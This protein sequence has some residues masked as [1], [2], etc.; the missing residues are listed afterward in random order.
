MAAPPGG[1]QGGPAVGILTIFTCPSPSSQ[2]NRSPR[3]ITIGSIN[4]DLVVRSDRLPVAGETMIAESSAWLPGGKGANQA[5][6]A[7][8]LGARV[9]FAGCVGRDAC[10]DDLRRGLAASGV[11]TEHLETAETAS[12]L[13]IIL[14]EPDGENRILV[15]P[16]ANDGVLPELVDRVLADAVLAGRAP[17]ESGQRNRPV[18]LLQ[19]EVPLETVHHAIRRGG[20]LGLPVVLDAGPPRELDLVQ[21]RGLTVLSPNETEAMALTGLPVTDLR[22]AETAARHLAA[23]TGARHVVLKLGA[24]GSLWLRENDAQHIP[25]FPVEPVD[26]TAAG[27]AFTA[28]LAVGLASGDL[29][30]EALHRANAAGALATT[31]AGAWPS[32]PEASAVEELLASRDTGHR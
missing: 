25:P 11:D 8:R 28:A 23:A 21:L 14:V 15:A 20:E 2:V 6:A 7:A 4:Q 12:G 9:R 29:D 3:V 18:L 26:T 22:E 5:V 27:D 13:A 19:L 10:G 31:R 16:G 30:A 17:E 1:R 24:A 32:L